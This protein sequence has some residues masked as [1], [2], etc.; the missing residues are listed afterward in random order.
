MD[1][2]HPNS[3]KEN[4]LRGIKW[5]YAVIALLAVAVAAAA[6]GLLR[7]QL[8]PAAVST[9]AKKKPGT[10]AQHCHRQRRSSW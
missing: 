4:T 6:L 9:S 7:P 5:P 2:S 1:A 10:T 3:Y 8:S